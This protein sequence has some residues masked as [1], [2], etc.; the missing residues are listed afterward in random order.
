LPKKNDMGEVQASPW[1]KKKSKR[2][3]G[4]LPRRE[5]E[6]SQGGGEMWLVKKTSWTVMN[7]VEPSGLKIEKKLP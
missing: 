6:L 2:G 3:D 5:R 7:P 4:R 1:E